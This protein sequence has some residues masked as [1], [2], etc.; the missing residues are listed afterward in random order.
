MPGFEIRAFSC[1]AGGWTQQR[2]V[3]KL[4]NGIGI[5]FRNDKSAEGNK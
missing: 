1:P 2:M 3:K 4:P 5:G